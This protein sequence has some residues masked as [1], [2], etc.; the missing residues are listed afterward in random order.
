MDLQH[1]KTC[2]IFASE[3]R[4]TTFKTENGCLLRQLLR[5]KIQHLDQKFDALGSEADKQQTSLK[6][7]IDQSFKTKTKE[8]TK[9]IDSKFERY[10]NI[11]VASN[12]ELKKEVESKSSKLEAETSTDR[13]HNDGEGQVTQVA[14]DVHA[15]AQ[16]AAKMNAALQ[17]TRKTLRVGG[18]FH[19]L[20]Q[21][22]TR[23]IID[24]TLIESAHLRALMKKQE[25]IDERYTFAF[26]IHPVSKLWGSE[27]TQHSPA[28]FLPQ[29]NTHVR[30]RAWFSSY[31]DSIYVRLVHA[32]GPP[33]LGLPPA[34]P[35]TRVKVTAAVREGRYYYCDHEAYWEV[36]SGEE[37]RVDESEEEEGEGEFWVWHDGWVYARDLWGG[38]WRFVLP[39]AELETRELVDDDRVIVCFYVEV[40]G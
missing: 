26:H 20:L 32:R 21:R 30:A 8:I 7:E 27:T 29:A 17:K 11:T 13:D 12:T 39:K 28:W 22:E 23:A 1:L 9:V 18:T 14:A 33:A 31:E 40:L 25:I 10:I 19:K 34:T 16:K 24:Q 2:H 35:A 36:V 15:L 37:M 6:K 38:G 3:R 5:L 4:V